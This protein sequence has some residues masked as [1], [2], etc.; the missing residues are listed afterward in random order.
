MGIGNALPIRI[1]A[2]D[3]DPSE[4]IH[5]RSIAQV[6]GYAIHAS[7]GEIGHVG[8]FIIDDQTWQLLDL[9]VDTH[10]WIGGKKV[11]IEVSHVHSISFLN[12]LVYVH[13][14]IA[15]IIDSQLFQENAYSQH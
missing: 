8:D 4:D 14:P 10:N 3:R 6:S 9:V 15:A 2:I 1:K 7:D 12:W 5:L 13:I 11:L